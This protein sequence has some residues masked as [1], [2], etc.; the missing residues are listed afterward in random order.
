VIV[1]KK[2]KMDSDDSGEQKSTGDSLSG[3]SDFS[4]PI[5][6]RHFSVQTDTINKR[7]LGYN[8]HSLWIGI[9]IILIFTFIL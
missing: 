8:V 3:D 2:N 4:K 1:T 9:C 5:W 7:L 6:V